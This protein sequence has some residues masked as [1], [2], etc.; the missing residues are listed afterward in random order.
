MHP[1]DTKSYSNA[2]SE[3]LSLSDDVNRSTI[4]KRDLK[5][6]IVLV[7]HVKKQKVYESK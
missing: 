1:D 5:E 7:M 2:G 4:Q 3:I 6:K